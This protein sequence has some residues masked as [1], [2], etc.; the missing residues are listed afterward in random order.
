MS[1]KPKAINIPGLFGE[2]TVESILTD[3][4]ELW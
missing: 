2:N 1:C 4:E 3:A